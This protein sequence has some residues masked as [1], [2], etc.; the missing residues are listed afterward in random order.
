MASSNT[1]R[2]AAGDTRAN[3]T[4][5]SDVCQYNAERKG[6]MFS[7]VFSSYLCLRP[8]TE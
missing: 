5:S 1:P 4:D 6:V 3:K 7:G 2:A 8:W